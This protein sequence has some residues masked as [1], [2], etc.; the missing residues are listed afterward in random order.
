V[1]SA[2]VGLGVGGAAVALA[3]TV[4]ADGALVEVADEAAV[5]LGCGVGLSVAVGAP[6]GARVGAR[7][8]GVVATKL[9]AGEKVAVGAG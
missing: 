2:A 3:A 5:A 7:V 9:T 8:G 4:V 1:K 6:V